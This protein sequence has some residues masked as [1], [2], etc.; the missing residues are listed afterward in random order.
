MPK[1]PD[2]R[3]DS[4]AA[5]AGGTVR[6]QAAALFLLLA[7]CA[8]TP[9]PAVEADRPSPLL[10]EIAARMPGD[11]ISVQEEAIRAQSLSIERIA[12]AAPRN[13]G[14]SLVQSNGQGE[15]VRRYGL[16]LEPGAIENRL[17]GEFALL[18]AQGRTRRSCGMA[19]HATRQGLIG[20]TDPASCRFGE[21]EGRV[22]LL[23][24]IAFDGSRLTIA[25]RLVDPDSGEALGPDRV[26]RFLPIRVYEGWLG[27]LEGEEWRVARAFDL[28]TGA[29]TEPRDAA[30]M[31]LGVSIALDYYRMERG[32]DDVLM[33]LTVTDSQDGELLAESWAAPGSE[34]IGIAL[35][36]LQIGLNLPD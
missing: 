24:E 22:G 6:L 31:S 14:L 11:Y 35:P 20:E 21:A 34:T 32:D 10:Q 36:D 30:D 28:R 8:A 25:D 29:S 7:G 9:E 19:F 27:V 5:C 26:I 16:K 2:T 4:G 1:H 17:D 3:K 18:D 12:S 33:R 15:N 23:K 13:L